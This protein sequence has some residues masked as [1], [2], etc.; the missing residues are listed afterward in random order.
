MII[1]QMHSN[2]K[3]NS[4][5]DIDSE[6]ISLHNISFPQKIWINFDKWM[7]IVQFVNIILF[8]LFQSKRE[9]WILIASFY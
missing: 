9:I 8:L 4:R 2:F 3:I 5:S 7:V 6:I 1:Y